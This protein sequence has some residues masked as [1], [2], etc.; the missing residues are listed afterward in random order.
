MADL[1]TSRNR[2]TQG[3]VTREEMYREWLGIANP[4]PSYYGLLGLP[5]LETDDAAVLG[6]GR[7]VKRKVRAYQIGL[8][9]KQALD[10]LA[11]IGQAVSV[12]TNAR[13]KK[14]YD[15]ELMARW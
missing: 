13:K 2:A 12:L 10:L 6:A 15:G 9:R 3:G 14:A 5:E 8:Y 1:H 4:A 11:E 7:R